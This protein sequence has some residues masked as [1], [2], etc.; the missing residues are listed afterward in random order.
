MF[1]FFFRICKSN[2]NSDTN[3][4]GGRLNLY[5]LTQ[6]MRVMHEQQVDC[7]LGAGEPF[8]HGES[9]GGE[10]C[11]VLRVKGIGLHSDAKRGQLLHA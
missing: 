4:A 3:P 2:Q 10:S 9:D 1:S 6:K 7:H 8:A 5:F 11:A